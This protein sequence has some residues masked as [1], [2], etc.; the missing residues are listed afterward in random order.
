MPPKPLKTVESR[1]ITEWR[2]WL[3]RH[4]ETESEVWL[5]FYK[6]H[7]GMPTVSY[8]DALDE[9]LCFGWIDSLVRRL[10][11]DRYARKFTPRKADSR[12]SDINRKRYGELKNEGRLQ[13]AGIDQAPTDRSYDPRPVLAEGVPKY[14]KDGLKAHPL[15]WQTF[16]K[17][18]PSHRRR[19]VGWITLAKRPETRAKRLN[20]AVRLLAEGKQLGLK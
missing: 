11:D 6:Q 9:A 18:A 4:H 12:W 3:A 16:E 5:I 19:Y 15:A 8:K 10:D 7:T 13:P 2:K 20:E 1:N 17:L 14:I